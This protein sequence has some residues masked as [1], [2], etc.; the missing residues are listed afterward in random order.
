MAA[1]PGDRALTHVVNPVVV[2][3]L[4]SPAH[5]LI[6]RHVAVIEVTGRRSGRRLR[7]PV[8]YARADGHLA[9]A[10]RPSRRWWR[11]LRG[12]APVRVLLRGRWIDGVADVAADGDRI[13]VRI[14]LAR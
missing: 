7:V 12:G 1:S 13:A 3:L 6:S 5:R 10:S 11:N 9:V 4:R 2:A 8:D 14:E